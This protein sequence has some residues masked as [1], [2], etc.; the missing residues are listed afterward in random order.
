MKLDE[1][2]LDIFKKKTKNWYKRTPFGLPSFMKSGTATQIYLKH[3]NITFRNENSL[4][5]S[6]GVA[7]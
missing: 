5:G 4:G 2:E 1:R 6:R 7:P 3:I